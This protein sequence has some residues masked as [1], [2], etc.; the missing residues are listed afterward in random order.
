LGKKSVFTSYYS[1]REE[2]K[3]FRICGVLN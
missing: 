1:Y 2:E 3:S